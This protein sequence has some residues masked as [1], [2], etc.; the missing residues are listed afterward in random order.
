[1]LSCTCI[2][3]AA[4]SRSVCDSKVLVKLFDVEK[5]DDLEIWVTGHSSSFELVQFKS[6]GA[7]SYLFFHSSYRSIL[8]HLRDKARYWSKIVIFFIP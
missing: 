2:V 7:V 8:Y 6:L 5:Y 3:C 4:D 1:M